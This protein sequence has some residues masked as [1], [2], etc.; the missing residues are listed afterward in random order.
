MSG[1]ESVSRGCTSKPEHL[2]MM[3]KT[4][5]IAQHKRHAA[6]QYHMKC[7]TGDL[8]NGGPFPELP[9]MFRG[10]F[11]IQQITPEMNVKRVCTCM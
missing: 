9:P 4:T 6:G 1:E 5:L 7:C 11:F 3:C 8:C 2:P 10:I